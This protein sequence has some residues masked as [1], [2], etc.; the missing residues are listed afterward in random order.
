VAPFEEGPTVMTELA[1]RRRSTIQ[2]VFAL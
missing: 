2:A 1:E